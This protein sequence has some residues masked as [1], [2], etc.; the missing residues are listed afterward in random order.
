MFFEKTLPSG[1]RIVGQKL[2]HFRSVSMG[3]WIGTGSVKER[4]NES[5]ISH[6]IEHMLF[7]G[8][9]TR[10]AQEI[11]VEMDAIGAQLN[12]FTSKECT[13]FYAKFIDEHM[14][15]AADVLSDMVKHSAL[16]PVEIEKEKGV[17]IEEI[18][19]VE[20]MPE[21]VVMELLSAT[22]FGED[23]Y[24]KPI[25][26]T[27]ESVRSFTDAAIRDYMKRHYDSRNTIVAAA[28]NFDEE[29]LS[30]LVEEY[31]DAAPTTAAAEVY[32]VAAVPQGVRA[33]VRDMDI[34]QCHLALALPSV[35]PLHELYYPQMILNNALGG[36]MS[37]RLFQKI[38]EDRGL[39]YSVYS[40]HSAYKDMGTFGVYAGTGGNQG[41]EVLRL[42]LE[43]L[44][45]VRHHSI[46]REEFVR[47]KE[48]LKGSY[49][50]A[51]ES[52][53]ARMNSIGKNLLL[54]NRLRTEEE[55]IQSIERVS[56]EQ[57]GE[58]SAKYLKNEE[59]TGAF[60]GR[61]CKLDET[62]KTAVR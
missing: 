10:T 22:F 39:A 3:C 36:S 33:A 27:R 40:F 56:Y 30:D 15:K 11:A 31:F 21:D 49:I 54:H 55:V 14:K 16:D 34:E 4:S 60:V 44:D 35:G 8:T 20:D 26:G 24:G 46:T 58:F 50:L 48:Q 47:S 12:A 52:V 25:L 2:P 18:N 42:I 59:L 9:M 43:E 19:M 32:P 29:E 5:G 61:G 23:P 51:N 41:E 53:G 17:V 57:V 13:C 38:R 28:G 45:D 7:K 37:S 6:F 1:L 62:L